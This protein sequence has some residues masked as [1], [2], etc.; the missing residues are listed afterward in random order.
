VIKR[1]FAVPLLLAMLLAA[2]GGGP[3]ATPADTP[4]ATPAAE[5]PQPT[6][7]PRP[8]DTPEPTDTPAPLETPEPAETPMGSETMEP[9]GEVDAGS[10]RA[11]A[12]VTPEE[13]SQI[14]G[15]Q[16]SI[17][18]ATANECT[19]GSAE[20]FPIFVLRFG[21]GET[22]EA[23]KMIISNGRDLTISGLP[24]FYGE[25]MGGILY[26]ERGSDTLVVQAPLQAE[27][28]IASQMER[29]AELAVSRWP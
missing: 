25:L 6:D 7:T 15:S 28:D 9:G 2:C 18:A 13:V 19:Y 3:A 27:G 11:C 8:T 24:A 23:A 21:F 10:S 12:L 17:T 29:I 22:I 26:V 1:L 14:T 16:M 4:T 5:S 20:I